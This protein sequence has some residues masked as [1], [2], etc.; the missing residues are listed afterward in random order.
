MAGDYRNIGNTLESQRNYDEALSYH[1]KA[2]KIHEGL[3]DKVKMAKDYNNIG[4]VL[5][6]QGNHDQA[7]EYHK[8][9]LAIDEKL[10]DKVK[11]AADYV[12]I[13]VAFRNQADYDEAL[14]YHRKALKIHEGLRDKVKMAKDYGYIGAVFSNRSSFAIELGAL[15]SSS[16]DHGQAIESFSKGLEIFQEL[17]EKKGYRHP[18]SDKIQEAISQLE[19]IVYNRKKFKAKDLNY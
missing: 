13:G 12:N 8:K 5:S 19:G 15:F 7:L 17:E 9:A 6:N 3:R 14:S 10:K 16:R 1:R 11:M 2:L 4:V 18:F